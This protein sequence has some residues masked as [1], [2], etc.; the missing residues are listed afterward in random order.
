[1]SRLRKPAE[2]LPVSTQVPIDDQ[3]MIE[4]PSSST[5]QAVDSD[6]DVTGQAFNRGSLSRCP[7][8]GDEEK[9]KQRN[10]GVNK[11]P[12]HMVK[13]SKTQ[14]SATKNE[15][16]KNAR[17]GSKEKAAS[18]QSQPAIQ[19]TSLKVPAEVTNSSQNIQKPKK[20]K[21]TFVDFESSASGSGCEM[22]F[23]KDEGIV[24]AG[25]KVSCFQL[26]LMYF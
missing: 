23:S 13:A 19:A 15:K 2:P 26:A 14:V 20:G 16:C 5:N 3:V 17:D 10:E 21:V 22:D 24:S 8:R 9:K 1:M 7:I 18:Q 25:F 4:T 6:E 12:L 11:E